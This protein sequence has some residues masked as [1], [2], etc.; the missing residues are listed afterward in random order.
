MKTLKTLVLLSA[1][2][3]TNS[4]ASLTGVSLI[5]I[6]HATNF[7]D[8]QS[9]IQITEVFAKETLTGND[10]ASASA[11]ASATASSY[12]WSG[13]PSYAIDD[14]NAGGSHGGGEF[15]S[16]TSSAYEFLNISLAAPASLDEITIF[17][18]SD[19]SSFRDMYDLFLYDD[20]NNLIFSA[21]DLDATG[22]NH[23]VT[24]TMPVPEPSILALMGLGIFGLGLSRRKMKK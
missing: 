22:A 16:A 1:L 12:G 2:F 5:Q 23:S 14:L 18:R 19:G 7:I 3:A 4:F 15:H 13:L 24:V 20:S 17:G 21:F 8:S 6:K 10:L 11:S 9:Y